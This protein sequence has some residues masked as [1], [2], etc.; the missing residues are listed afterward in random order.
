MVACSRDN[1]GKDTNIDK[2]TNI[3]KGTNE[4]VLGYSISSM[5]QIQSQLTFAS[6]GVGRRTSIIGD[7]AP[8]IPLTNNG[9]THP[10]VLYYP[11]GFKNYKY[12]ISLS[13]CFGMIMKLEDPVSFENPYIFCSN[14]GINWKEPMPNVNPIDTPAPS[15]I[16]NG[17][18]SDPSLLPLNGSLQLYYRGNNMTNKIISDGGLRSVVYRSSADGQNWSKR[19]ELFSTLNNIGADNESMLASPSVL[20]DGNLWTCYDVVYSSKKHP[21]ESQ[22]NQT[23]G[24]VERRQS[25]SSTSGFNKKKTDICQ[26]SNRPWG[27][28]N[29]PWHLEVRKVNGIYFMLL[30]T[31]LVAKS[32]GE[33]LYLALSSDGVNFTV[34][35]T[36]LFSMDTYKSSIVPIQIEEN[37]IVFRLYQSKKSN[38]SINLYELVLRK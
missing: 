34:F 31:G 23:S 11:E 9:Y 10:S 6:V 20:Q 24:F 37:K 2:E 16:S 38:G 33:S 8:R 17:Y 15:Y 4:V 13:P 22:G 26:F 14:D 7:N 27:P 30:T 19:A 28:A 12:W 1:I 3:N 5:K 29:D 25:I 36:P 18:W 35:P 32:N 21:I